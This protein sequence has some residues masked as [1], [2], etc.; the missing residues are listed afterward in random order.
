MQSNSPESIAPAQD[1]TCTDTAGSAW[2]VYILRCA[3]GSLYTGVTTDLQR[4]LREHNSAGG[5]ARYTRSRRPVRLVYAERAACRSTACRRECLLKRFRRTE[6]EA[7]IASA[8]DSSFS[9]RNMV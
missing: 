4:R 1:Q 2:H 5:G 8:D 7:L 9:L 6:K 3:D